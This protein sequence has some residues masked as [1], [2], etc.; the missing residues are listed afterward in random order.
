MTPAPQTLGPIIE[1]FRHESEGTNIDAKFSELLS[2]SG[3]ASRTKDAHPAFVTIV[4]A[5]SSDEARLLHAVAEKQLGATNS[6]FA[7]P[8]IESVGLPA[9]LAYPD[10]P[11]RT[12]VT[13]FNS[14]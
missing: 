10:N 2:T 3:H 5:L 11:G 4:R 8:V 1:A 9:G 6:L 12:L 13:W 14:A 7:P